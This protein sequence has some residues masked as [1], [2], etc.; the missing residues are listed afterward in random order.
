VIFSKSIFGTSVVLE[1]AAGAGRELL[2]AASAAVAARSTA[3][4]AR[5]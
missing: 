3:A 5:E 1:L 2:Q 4:H